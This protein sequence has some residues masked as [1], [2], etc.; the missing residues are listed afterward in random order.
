MT[1]AEGGIG[2]RLAY[3][4]YLVFTGTPFNSTNQAAFQMMKSPEPSIS[5]LNV[6]TRTKRNSPPRR[7]IVV[8]LPPG[9]FTSVCTWFPSFA[10]FLNNE[11]KGYIKCL[12]GRQA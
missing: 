4:G 3:N 11:I 8:R 2:Q 5:R 9:P 6:H 12:I 7:S 10:I 1:G